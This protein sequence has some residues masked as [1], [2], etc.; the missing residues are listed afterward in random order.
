MILSELSKQDKEALPFHFHAANVDFIGTHTL[1][2][3]SAIW[4][5]QLALQEPKVWK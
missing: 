2:L 5:P 3:E 4:E 1:C